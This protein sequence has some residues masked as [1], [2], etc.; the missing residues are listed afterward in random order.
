MLASSVWGVP[1]GCDVLLEAKGN[2]TLIAWLILCLVGRAGETAMEGELE[3]TELPV[4]SEPFEAAVG[5][6]AE[7]VLAGVLVAGEAV[8]VCKGLGVDE[9]EATAGRG[10]I[11]VDG[12]TGVFDAEEAAERV[13]EAPA[14]LD[15][16]RNEGP[17]VDAFDGVLVGVCSEN[18]DDS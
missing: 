14:I 7:A 9:A 13:D 12:V 15:E 4:G 5:R 1:P 11:G 8:A 3:G 17:D 18:N 10:A 2:R 6:F 16:D